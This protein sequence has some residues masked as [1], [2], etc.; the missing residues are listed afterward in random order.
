MTIIL[1][2]VFLQYN[3][4]KTRELVTTNYIFSDMKKTET[5]PLTYSLVKEYLKVYSSWTRDQSKVISRMERECKRVVGLH[6]F[7][8]LPDSEMWLLCIDQW[9]LSPLQSDPRCFLALFPE[10][11]KR[12]TDAARLRRLKNRGSLFLNRRGGMIPLP[13]EIFLMEDKRL[14]DFLPPFPWESRGKATAEL[15]VGQNLSALSE[16]GASTGSC[17]LS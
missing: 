14:R 2:L 12:L 4:Q 11:G 3:Y 10:S 6:L 8:S 15:G 1:A 17:S 13:T 5:I 9:I 7:I 16:G